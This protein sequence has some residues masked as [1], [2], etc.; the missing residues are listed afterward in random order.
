M[1][2]YYL[3][4]GRELGLQGL[5]SNMYGSMQGGIYVMIAMA[6]CMEV[7]PHLDDGL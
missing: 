2:V 4:M 1:Y 7:K 3:S 5:S 6:D